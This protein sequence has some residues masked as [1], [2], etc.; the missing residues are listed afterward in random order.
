MHT[1][2]SDSVLTSLSTV[3]G[4]LITLIAQSNSTGR[5]PELEKTSLG[6][7]GQV[8][9]LRQVAGQIVDLY[10]ASDEVVKSEMAKG[11]ETGIDLRLKVK[12]D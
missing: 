2:S 6:V 9:A 1:Q 3:V 8:D 5:F 4:D 10:G 11:V 7:V 12:M